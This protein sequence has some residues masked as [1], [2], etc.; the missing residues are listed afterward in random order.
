MGAA[1]GNKL[2]KIG[3]VDMPGEEQNGYRGNRNEVLGVELMDSEEDVV[4]LCE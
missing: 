4:S 2:L 1:V 3:A